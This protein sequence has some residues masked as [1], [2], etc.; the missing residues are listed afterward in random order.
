MNLLICLVDS[1]IE[2]SVS[3]AFIGFVFGPIYPL[4]LALVSDS[5]PLEVR[6]S[7]LSIV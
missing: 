4:V 3:T 2:N 7:T 1:A 5:L 6:M